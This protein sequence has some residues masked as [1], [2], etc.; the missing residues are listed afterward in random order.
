MDAIDEKAWNE[1][2]AFW[3]WL[4]ASQNQKTF[5]ERLTR[6]ELKYGSKRLHSV[7]YIKVIWLDPYKERIIKAWVD[8]YL[9]FGNVATSR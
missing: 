4:V 7:G 5:S 2:N 6:F 8:E 1:F 9:H 3:H